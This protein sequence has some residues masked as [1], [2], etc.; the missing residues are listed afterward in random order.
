MGSIQAFVKN[1][2]SDDLKTWC[3]VEEH[4]FI[5]EVSLLE[6]AIRDPIIKLLAVH[7]PQKILDFDLSIL[8]SKDSDTRLNVDTGIEVNFNEISRKVISMYKNTVS[9]VKTQNL[10]TFKVERVINRL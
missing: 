6:H 2:S 9:E 1:A 10:A 5:N 3:S 4:D 7:K 8:N